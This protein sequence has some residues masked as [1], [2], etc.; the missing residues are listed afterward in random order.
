MPDRE[1]LALVIPLA[2]FAGLA[3]WLFQLDIFVRLA[4]LSVPTGF[5]WMAD[6]G[7]RAATG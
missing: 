5:M 2:I 1:R 7:K 3:D 4:L 6:I